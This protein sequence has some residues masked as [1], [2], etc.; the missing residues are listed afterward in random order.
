MF[1]NRFFVYNTCGRRIL[2]LIHVAAS[3]MRTRHLAVIR[4]PS[5]SERSALAFFYCFVHLLL[6]QYSNGHSGPC[7]QESHREM[8]ILMRL[9]SVH[10]LVPS[11]NFMRRSSSFKSFWGNASAPLNILRLTVLLPLKLSMDFPLRVGGK[12]PNP[13]TPEKANLV[14]APG[15]AYHIRLDVFKGILE[16]SSWLQLSY[17]VVSW[18]HAHFCDLGFETH[19][20]LC[21]KLRYKITPCA[22]I[23][24][25][26]TLLEYLEID[27][28]MPC[29]IL[30]KFR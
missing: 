26:S 15:F 5:T 17:C 21:L 20:S 8:I 2:F 18:A 12:T 24:E 16:A 10:G 14:C 13:F 6:R 4:V 29:L 3:D 19:Q 9:A 25:T 11:S 27:L 22:H 23:N 1:D 28:L 30:T 7:M